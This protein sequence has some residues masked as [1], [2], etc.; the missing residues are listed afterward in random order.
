MLSSCL[1][2]PLATPAVA[3]STFCRGHLESAACCPLSVCCGCTPCLPVSTTNVALVTGANRGVG[4]YTAK[5]LLNQGLTV[6]LLCRSLAR[7]HRA[8]T[9]LA[10]LTGNTNVEAFHVDL[11][12][13]DTVATF[14]KEV[15][16]RHVNVVS[17]VNNAGMIG[18]RAMRINHLGH[19]ALTVGLMPALQRGARINRGPF[20]D[21]CCCYRGG[22]T[23]VNVASVAHIQGAVSM[24]AEVVALKEMTRWE[25]QRG[26]AWEKYSLS[27]AANVLFT[28]SLA[29][30][31][32]FSSGVRVSS[33]APGVMASDLWISEAQRNGS[34]EDRERAR[35]CGRLLV[36]PCVKHPCMSAAGVSALA[37]PRCACVPAPSSS[38]STTS[39][40]SS[41]SSCLVC[42]CCTSLWGSSG[43]YYQQFGQVCVVPVRPMPNMY[44]KKLQHDL[45]QASL[46]Q[47][48][49]EN[50]MLGERLKENLAEMPAFSSLVGGGESRNELVP[51]KELVMD[52]CWVSPALPC[53]EI[54]TCLPYCV[55]AAFLF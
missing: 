29:T 49:R 37:N 8:A 17:L 54:V 10:A 4:Y 34:E 15:E 23:V 50:A 46:A 6:Y 5:S 7:G 43:G 47:I 52:R 14:V 33:Y 35:E 31:L 19:F 18:L 55:C 13:L 20:P 12:Q 51:P 38:S 27:K 26:D 28:H 11:G 42:C 16:R 25:P 2:T 1:C 21:A 48:Q 30:Q 9:K 53:T 32:K 44:H 41:I 36:C 24:A 45:W 40:M 3:L 22:S 39:M